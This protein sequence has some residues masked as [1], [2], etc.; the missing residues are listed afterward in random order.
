MKLHSELKWEPPTDVVETDHEI[1]VVVEIAGMKGGDFDIMTDGR[2]LSISGI[3][4]SVSPAGKKQFHTLEIQA[5]PFERK[6]TLPVPVDD[7]KVSATY[8]NGI[9]E[10]TIA[11]IRPQKRSRRVPIR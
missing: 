9:L 8:R 3:R 11:K 5:G 6:V 10:V 4:R 2:V 7:S 1:F